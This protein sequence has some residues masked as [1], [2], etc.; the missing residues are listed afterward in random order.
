MTNE[1]RPNPDNIPKKALEKRDSSENSLLPDP[2]RQISLTHARNLTIHEESG[3]LE[4]INPSGQVELQ[5]KITDQGP[6]LVFNHAKLALT[7]SGDVDLQCQNLSLKASGR[8]KMMSGASFEQRVSGS[9]NVQVR[10]DASMKAQSIELDAELGELA[11]KANDDVALNGLRVLMNVPS[12]EELQARAKHL[13]TFS[14]Y[15]NMPFSNPDSPKR[16]PKSTPVER[17]LE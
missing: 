4:I 6:V 7:N 2:S 10:D 9:Y 3:L 12:D 14:D 17:E 8:L 15:L 5:V 1:S 16:M 11:L 13:K